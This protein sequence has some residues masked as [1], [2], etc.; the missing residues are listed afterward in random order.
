MST[1]L[2]EP[3]VHHD[4][5]MRTTIQIAFHPSRNDVVSI[6]AR[7]AEPGNPLSRVKLHALVTGYYRL[8]GESNVAPPELIGA[9]KDW[10]RRSIWA[11]TEVT[12]LYPEWS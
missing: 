12:R 2:A 3:R 5:E 8:W 11:D 10:N 9:N 1:A 4:G 7:S 6:V